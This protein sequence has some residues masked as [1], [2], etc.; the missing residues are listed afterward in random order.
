MKTKVGT[1]SFVAPEVLN[2][3]YGSECDIWSLGVLLYFMLSGELPFYGENRAELYT[4]I[5]SGA[6][7]ITKGRWAKISV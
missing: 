4:S 7:N 3:S 1:P 6:I 2:G 5:R